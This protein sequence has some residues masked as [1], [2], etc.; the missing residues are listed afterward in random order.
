MPIPHLTDPLQ[1]HL[2]H[3]LDLLET[4]INHGVDDDSDYSPVL[5]VSGLEAVID[6]CCPGLGWL[7]VTRTFPSDNFPAPATTRAGCP[8]SMWACELEIG[9]ARC[10]C[11][12]D[13]DTMVPDPDCLQQEV[14]QQGL[15]RSAL[16]QLALCDLP[17]HFK[18]DGGSECRIVIGQWQPIP[19]QG[20]CF[21]GSITITFPY[22]QCCDDIG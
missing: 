5:Q 9:V 6:S 20:G 13:E 1:P 12:V 19:T 16:Q 7:R 15:D 11:L 10:A 3:I 4:R 2:E 14:V 18:E 22:R 8:V 21:G 17:S